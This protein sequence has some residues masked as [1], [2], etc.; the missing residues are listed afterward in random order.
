MSQPLRL[1]RLDKATRTRCDAASVAAP[2]PPP[3]VDVTVELDPE[4]TDGP[5]PD[6]Q[7]D[8]AEQ[9]A[10]NSKPPPRAGK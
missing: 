8:P 5:T 9:A 10:T 1:F 3:E 6:L 4:D 2:E 7:P